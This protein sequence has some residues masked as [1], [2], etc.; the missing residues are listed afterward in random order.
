MMGDFLTNV[1]ARN[2]EAV[3][4][5]V[6]RVASRFEPVSGHP[7]PSISSDVAGAADR[8]YR[9][10]EEVFLNPA[11]A[12][13]TPR[14]AAPVRP[15]LPRRVKPREATPVTRSAADEMSDPHPHAA[16]ED[17]QPP[18][19]HSEPSA[20]PTVVTAVARDGV[21]EAPRQSDELPPSRGSNPPPSLRDEPAQTIVRIEQRDER[22]RTVETADE[23]RPATTVTE[24]RH[25]ATAPPP[26]R[27][28]MTVTARMHEPGP[29]PGPRRPAA[30]A[31][32]AARRPGS[33]HRSSTAGE[34]V[35]PPSASVSRSIVQVRPS[36]SPPSETRAV[37]P[38]PAAERLSA[39]V[40]RPTS[41]WT[42]ATPDRRQAP[43]AEQLRVRQH[44]RDLP[45][46]TRPEPETTVHVTIGRLEVKA[47]PT[48][49][50]ARTKPSPAS[51]SGLEEYLRRRARGGG[52]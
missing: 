10:E 20:A 21:P 26:G 41:E 7:E 38:E 19:R 22:A 43:R 3:D 16:A 15:G 1:I 42:F 44:R 18:V 4:R 8:I 25:D 31:A 27:N 11:P 40:P 46:G 37:P 35:A 32:E 39:D 52:Q 49:A 33:P 30:A 12:R 6:P 47:T 23:P 14:M 17:V 34:S 13:E 9:I 28:A 5:L 29:R 36:V 45:G 48:A 50:P 2:V 24:E 51:A